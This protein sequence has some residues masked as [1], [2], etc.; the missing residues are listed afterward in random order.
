MNSGHLTVG[1]ELGFFWLTICFPCLSFFVTAICNIPVMIQIFIFCSGYIA[2]KG[3]KE[4]NKEETPV[5]KYQRLNCEVRHILCLSLPE[6]QRQATQHGCLP[7][8]LGD[9]D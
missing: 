6:T 8:L 4:E 5:K 9:G 7:K 1:N 2:W 3:E